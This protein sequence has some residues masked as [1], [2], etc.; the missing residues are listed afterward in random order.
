MMELEFCRDLNKISKDE[1]ITQNIE[2]NYISFPASVKEKVSLPD[3]DAIEKEND[4][5]IWI[6]NVEFEDH[7]EFSIALAQNPKLFTLDPKKTVIF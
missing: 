6:Y 1:M 7:D 4:L 3:F 2:K 5:A